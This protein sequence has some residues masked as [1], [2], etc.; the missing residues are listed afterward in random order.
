MKK[1]S[2]DQMFRVRK[3]VASNVDLICQVLEQEHVTNLF[4]CFFPLKKEK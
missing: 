3:G 4:V 2:E 1:F